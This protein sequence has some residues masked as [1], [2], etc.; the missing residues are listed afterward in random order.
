MCGEPCNFKPSQGVFYC[1]RVGT[2]TRGRRQVCSFCVSER[3]G[4]FLGSTCVK[5]SDVPLS[6][7]LFLWKATTQQNA[8]DLLGLNSETCVNWSSYC[9]EVCEFWLGQQ[10]QISGPATIVEID[11]SK[12]GKTNYNRG[13][14]VEG[15]WV[16][17][18]LREKTGNSCFFQWIEETQQL[19]F[20]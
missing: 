4:T 6:T 17:G 1:K 19:S 5:P 15:K 9:Y 18:S 8:Q 7:G 2:D 16:F 20:P 10:A 3:R 14:N 12:F 13:R 11:K